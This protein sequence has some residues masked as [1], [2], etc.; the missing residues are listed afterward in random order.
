MGSVFSV[1]GSVLVSL[2]AL[3]WLA[4]WIWAL[5]DAGGYPE[6]TWQSAGESKATWF[7]LILVLQFFGTL[8]YLFSVRPK[9][10]AA[11]GE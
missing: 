1:V 9:L 7:L 2:A 11:A 3:G 4:M 6:D 10:Q 8:F 5:Q